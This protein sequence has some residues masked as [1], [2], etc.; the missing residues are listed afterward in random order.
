MAKKIIHLNLKNTQLERVNSV[1]SDTTDNPTLSLN[2]SPSVEIPNLNSNNIP[3]VENSDTASN[4]TSIQITT[5]KAPEVLK[6]EV[7]VEK[8]IDKVFISFYS[9]IPRLG[10]LVLVKGICKVYP[11]YSTEPGMTNLLFSLGEP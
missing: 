4:I 7:V 1:N 2:N 11:I 10:I 3:S 5:S 6:P 8:I 9:Y